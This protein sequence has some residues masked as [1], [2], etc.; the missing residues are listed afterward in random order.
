MT[1]VFALAVN[2]L[3]ALTLTTATPASAQPLPVTR[4]AY[5]AKYLCG[6]TDAVADFGILPGF[7]FEYTVVEVHNP[8]SVP[9][10]C[11]I[12]V[13]EDYPLSGIVVP[14]YLRTLG[15]NEAMEIDCNGLPPLGPPGFAYRTGFV[16]IN[17]PQQLKVVAVYKEA[18]GGRGLIKSA[19]IAKKSSPP[20]FFFGFVRHSGTF[21][22]GDAAQAGGDTIRHETTISIAN[23]S[24]SPVNADISIVNETG[25]VHAFNRFLQPNGFTAV[26]G[27]DLPA[28]VPRPFVGGV[29]VQYA[30]IG[31]GALFECEE[32]IQKH[33]ISGFGSTSIAMSVVEV[34][35]IPLR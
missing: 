10:T 21:L 5:S 20:F 26:T 14:P 34:Q 13:V 30:D 35:P 23:M 28:F 12:K 29:T 16:E 9:V 7:S 19:S 15:P 31:F 32:I 18:Y 1:S 2:L 24:P 3:A 25:V 27:A 22:V 8:H 11:I 17:S 6:Q 4:L 33:V